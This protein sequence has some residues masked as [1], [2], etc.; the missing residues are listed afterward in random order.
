MAPAEPAEPCPGVGQ[1]EVDGKIRASGT[2]VPSALNRMT[3]HWQGPGGRC[4][5]PS[6]HEQQ[7]VLADNQGLVP[8]IWSQAW[9]APFDHSTAAPLPVPCSVSA[10]PCACSCRRLEVQ[11]Q[12]CLSCEEFQNA[13]RKRVAHN[14]ASF[15]AEFT[16]SV[17]SFMDWLIE[18]TAG[19]EQAYG[20]FMRRSARG[21][22]TRRRRPWQP[23]VLIS[24]RFS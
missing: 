1:D 14:D 7:D 11:E 12:K 15:N 21:A 5:D 6:E 10:A 3:P 16:A 13:V 24:A 18:Q 8:T 9:C 20:A 23:T 17:P 19:Q 2:Y 22:R 4:L